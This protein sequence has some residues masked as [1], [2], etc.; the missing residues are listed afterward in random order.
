MEIIW[1]LWNRNA[2]ILQLLW[3]KDMYDRLVADE[4]A[5][6]VP[7]ADKLLESHQER[8]V[9]RRKRKRK[10]KLGVIH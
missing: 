4:L 3:A 8:K 2:C 10:E 1:I 6:N 9:R 5:K 7:D